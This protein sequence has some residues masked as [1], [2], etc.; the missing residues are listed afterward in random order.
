MISLSDK[1][2]WSGLFEE[3]VIQNKEKKLG[4]VLKTVKNDEDSDDSENS[5]DDE[6]EKVKEGKV[7]VAW[8]NPHSK[9]SD[10]EIKVVDEN[11]IELVDRSLLPGDAVRWVLKARG[12]QKGLVK[13]VDVKVDVV[14]VGTNYILKDIPVAL[15][16]PLD[17]NISCGTPIIKGSWLGIIRGQSIDL[18]VR[19]KNGSKCVISGESINELH[20]VT[21]QRDEDSTF[22]NNY[23]YPGQQIQGI[24]RV[25]KEA[26]W[27]L[28]TKPAIKNQG[29]VK[30]VVEQVDL[31]KLMI[32]W[33]LLG[34]SG[35][36]Q[37]TNLP[38]NQ[39]LTKEEVM[40]KDFSVLKNYRD[41]NIQIGDKAYYILTQADVDQCLSE[42]SKVTKKDKVN[43]KGA[44]KT[45]ISDDDDDSDSD[46]EV[47]PVIGTNS[48]S[49]A[50]NSSRRGVVR[51][52]RRR[53]VV[54][55]KRKKRYHPLV[56]FVAGEK[57]C[58]EI[59]KTKTKA[60]VLWQDGSF[61]E[62]IPSTELYPVMN[63]DDSEFF[64]GDFVVDKRA[65][66]LPEKFGVVQMA[67]NTARVCTV[68][69]FY[70]HGLNDKQEIENDVSVYDIA[71]HRD[72][73]FR[74]GD[75]VLRLASEDN[76]NENENENVIVSPAGQVIQVNNDGTVKVRW[77]DDSISSVK[78][79]NL[80]VVDHEDDD[81][82]DNEVENNSV[83]SLDGDEEEWET[84][85]DAS[86]A[87]FETVYDNINPL[88][89]IIMR[90]LA[91]LNTTSSSNNPH[92]GSVDSVIGLNQR[93]ADYLNKLSQQ[94]ARESSVDSTTTENSTKC[95]SEDVQTLDVESVFL[96]NNQTFNQTINGFS[97]VECVPSCHHFF[98]NV[99]VPTNTRTFNAAVLKEVKMIKAHLPSGIVVKSFDD[100]M[101]LFSVL[102][103]G[104]SGT[105]YEGG[106]FYFD[107]Q[108]PENYPNVPPL[109]HY[110]SYCTERLNPNLYEEGKVCVS[111]L[112]T[113]S[114][115]GSET[116]TSK[117]SLRQLLLSIQ[118]L[119]LCE[120]PYYNEA[121][122][123]KQR[124][125]DEGKENSRMYNE[126]AVIKNMQSILRLTARPPEIFLNEVTSY[127]QENLPRIIKKCENWLNSSDFPPA[128]PLFPLSKGFCATLSRILEQL[129]ENYSNSKTVVN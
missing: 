123:E 16:P 119:I 82:W 39:H 78:S 30:A 60:A 73:T 71:D 57:I 75:V 38:Y 12:S 32:D 91:S 126:M 27:I 83:Y 56:S 8:Y 105:P 23:F 108:L 90:S 114:G 62:N 86:D 122:Y 115:K 21:D 128:F 37:D 80:I 31:T 43:E 58:V 99:L 98:N 40:S 102:I 17:E 22:Y 9:W 44:S 100:R 88:E 54:L 113:W 120:E 104:P 118:G 33:Q 46:I 68:L 34:Y 93:T 125:T 5:S 84:A 61:S 29:K 35:S 70:G 20:D 106:I 41:N 11:S 107:M 10:D 67:D 51:P 79:T 92:V 72:Y 94:F 19:L 14:I 26:K 77:I 116:W 15:L 110:H 81:N 4:V 24:A 109:V 42:I 28:G 2:K 85:S 55:Q 74:A 124:G 45:V 112:G 97:S 50:P 49:S 13:S 47:E 76:S 101:D 65:N 36:Q 53:N 111:L 64:P 59:C 25:F 18:T 66:S 95:I 117:S 89:D 127:F 69:W 96:Q 87:T 3:D 6:H 129:R 7:M 52:R 103:Y 1:E 63:L 121:G 48:L